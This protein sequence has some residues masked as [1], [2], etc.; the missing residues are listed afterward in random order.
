MTLVL[1]PSTIC[2]KVPPKNA[3]CAN[4]LKFN[5]KGSQKCQK[6]PDFVWHDKFFDLMPNVFKMPQKTE[7][8]IKNA[9]MATLP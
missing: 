5:A 6:M 4:F 8:G 7:F 1:S 3:K 9:T 2:V